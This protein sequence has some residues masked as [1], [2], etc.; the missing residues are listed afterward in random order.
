M[1]SGI[2]KVGIQPQML[3]SAIFVDSL[4]WGYKSMIVFIALFSALKFSVV[5][6]LGLE[7]SSH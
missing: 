6:A 7:L 1:E 3:G 5:V 4:T 2:Q